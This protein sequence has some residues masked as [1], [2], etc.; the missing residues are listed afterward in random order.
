[1]YKDKALKLFEPYENILFDYGGIFFDIEHQRTVQ[2]FNQLSG[3]TDFGT[4]FSKHD[5]VE[6]FSLLETGKISKEIFLPQLK[7]LL[8]LT[9]IPDQKI[10]DAWCAMLI[11]IPQERVDFLRELKKTK[12]IFMLSNINQIHEDFAQDYIAKH[13]YLKD[14]YSLFDHVYFSHQ[15]G[16]RKPDAEVFEYVCFKS[17]LKKNTTL[18]L[19]DSIQHV[20]SARKCGL[21]AHHLDPA[22]SF[23]I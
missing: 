4:L 17:K 12:K 20:E 15:I 1:M 22:N 14:F 5:Q 18:F 10:I 2:A 11:K 23:I 3:L 13:E 16:L 19:D 6:I 7:K 8:A 9:H 21:T